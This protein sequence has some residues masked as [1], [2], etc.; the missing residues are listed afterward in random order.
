MPPTRKERPRIPKLT[1]PGFATLGRRPAGTRR[2]P[3]RA[4]TAPP[5]TGRS[6]SRPS[7]Q[8]A[9]A[10]RARQVPHQRIRV[11]HGSHAITIPD[12]DERARGDGRCAPE[13]PA[14]SGEVEVLEAALRKPCGRRITGPAGRGRSSGSRLR[15]TR[16]CPRRAEEL[17]PARVRFRPTPSSTPGPWP[18]QVRRRPRAGTV[19]VP[20]F[21]SRAGRTGRV[22]GPF[23]DGAR[24]RSPRSCHPRTSP[25]GSP[26]SP[27]GGHGG[28]R[29]RWRVERAGQ[30]GGGRRSSPASTA[31]R[32]ARIITS[33]RGGEE[34]AR[35]WS[36]WTRAEE[37]SRRGRGHAW[38]S[39]GTAQSLAWSRG[40]CATRAACRPRRGPRPDGAWG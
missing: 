32:P 37:P 24:R 35:R 17:H 28:D 1:A 30:E 7:G 15:R 18:A 39:G 27:R 2:L 4:S 9:S 12:D 16:R 5:R 31:A 8:R 38:R 36:A 10:P 21:P 14:D 3:R 34:R 6:G 26:G 29:P 13:R 11:I 25:P 20:S 23:R 40:C 19:R 33:W 22:G